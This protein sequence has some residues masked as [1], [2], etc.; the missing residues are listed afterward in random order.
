MPA[1]ATRWGS[2]SIESRSSDYAVVMK[3]VRENKSR[4]SW[5]SAGV[6]VVKFVVSLT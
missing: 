2:F 1:F 6:F 4:A 3:L 5:S